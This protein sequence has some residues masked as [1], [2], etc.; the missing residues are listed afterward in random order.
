[1]FLFGFLET[2]EIQ[3]PINQAAAKLS[4]VYLFGLKFRPF[5]KVI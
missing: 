4:S 2:G 1:M 5:V 3:E